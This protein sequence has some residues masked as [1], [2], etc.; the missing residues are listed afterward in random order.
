[1]SSNA[2]KTKKNGRRQ[3]I[4]TVSASKLS[5]GNIITKEMYDKVTAEL[6]DRTLQLSSL[7][8]SVLRWPPTSNLLKKS[9]ANTRKKYLLRHLSQHSQDNPHCHL[10]KYS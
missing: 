3:T 8:K 10:F 7:E 5:K 1:M 2:E 6:K 4:G 9:S